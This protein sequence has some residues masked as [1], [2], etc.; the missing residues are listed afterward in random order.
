MKSNSRRYDQFY[1]KKE[2]AK[3]CMISLKEE[4]NIEEFILIEP[5]AGTGSFSNFFHKNSFSF[6]I[7]PKAKGIIK[8][9]FLK[10]DTDFLKDEKVITI[11]NPPFGIKSTLAVNFFNKASEYSDY[12]AYIIPKTFKK[13]S[14]A[15]RLDLNFI[16]IKEEEL[17]KNSFLFEKENYSVPCVFQIWKKVPEKRIP[18]KIKTTSDVFEFTDKENADFA[19]RRVGL[20]AGKI[21]SDFNRYKK[22]S[23]Y[24]IKV[25]IC[26][27]EF[28]KILKSK[29]KELNKVANN[30][31]G[32]PSLSKHELIEIC[33]KDKLIT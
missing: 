14:I 12:I 8:Q 24:F 29:F 15:N 13:A 19:I 9:D 3:K 32:N 27:N 25:N 21:I 30:C 23:N 17:D 2:V 7:D 4:L 20:L 26:K 10:L 31:A 11:G 6:D 16:L 1:T 18:I 22:S 33:F 28:N 5:S